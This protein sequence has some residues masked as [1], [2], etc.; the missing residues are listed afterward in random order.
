MNAQE[1][2]P[3]EM[4]RPTRGAWIETHQ[5]FGQSIYFESRPTRGAW[6]E[7]IDNPIMIRLVKS[8][9]TRGAWIET[10]SAI[11]KF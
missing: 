8:R 9:P 2:V 1:T 3:F 5:R 6:I 7:T 4:S 10:T 11:E